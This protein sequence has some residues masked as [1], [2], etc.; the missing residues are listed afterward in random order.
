MLTF[1]DIR[2]AQL[3]GPTALTIGNFDGLHLGHQALLEKLRSVAQAADAQQPLRTAVLTFD[4]HPMTVFRP[5]EPLLLMTSAR[6]RLVLAAEHRI[7]FGIAHPFTRDT[8]S[9]EAH[10]FMTLLKQHLGLAAL[11]VGPDFALGR[12][13]TGTIER[14]R[15]LGEDYGYSVHVMQPF[16]LDGQPVRSS[17]V[18]E[19]LL[20]GDVA[21]AGRLLGRTYQVQGVVHA[22]DQRGRAV[23]I[24]TANV[25]PAPDKLLPADGVYATRTRVC[26]ASGMSMFDSVTNI[27]VR[28]TVDG[29]QRRVETHLLHFPPATQIDDLYGQTLAI[30]FLQ[31]LRGEQRFASVADLVR[32]IHLDIE[33]ATL[34]FAQDMQ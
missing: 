8:A 13:R 1:R 24:P 20:A 2:Q 10:E 19:L 9:L 14:L 30:D 4:P 32:Q 12:N 18:R 22:G 33:R 34:L 28:P 21:E 7:D 26:S 6:D 11:V 29:T 31:R 17:R 25:A 27:G 23:G 5:G 16:L 3:P 15:E